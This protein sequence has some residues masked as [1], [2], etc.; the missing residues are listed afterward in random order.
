MPK[1]PHVD[2]TEVP[3]HIVV[4]EANFAELAARLAHDTKQVQQEYIF[5]QQKCDL[6]RQEKELVR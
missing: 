4:E 2:E 6:L 5:A 3:R 1:I